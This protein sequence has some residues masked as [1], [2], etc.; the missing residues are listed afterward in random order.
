MNQ[1]LYDMDDAG[2]LFRVFNG[3]RL[4]KRVPFHCKSVQTLRKDCSEFKD[5]DALSLGIVTTNTYTPVDLPASF[6]QL[7]MVLGQE[8]KSA[9]S[10]LAD[11]LKLMGEQ[12]CKSDP[13][14][15]LISDYSTLKDNKAIAVPLSE[16]GVGASGNRDTTIM[17]SWRPS[18]PATT[19][20]A[21]PRACVKPAS[22]MGTT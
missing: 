21:C 3:A 14:R 5:L 22:P 9:F 16:A 20:G 8:L 17:R 10:D 2:S 11:H 13:C 15:K 1:A 6:K 18:M 4:P 12:Y 7:P 19:S